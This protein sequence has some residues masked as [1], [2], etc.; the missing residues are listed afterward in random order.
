MKLAWIFCG[1]L[2]SH[3]LFQ[4]LRHPNCDVLKVLLCMQVAQGKASNKYPGV[5]TYLDFIASLT[6]QTVPASEMSSNWFNTPCKG[7]FLADSMPNLPG[8]LKHLQ[9]RSPSMQS[10]QPLK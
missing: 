6:L 1:C 10:S 2:A 3:A 4:A 7:G 5:K 8:A 9:V